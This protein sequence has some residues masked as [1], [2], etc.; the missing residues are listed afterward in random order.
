MT[1]RSVRPVAAGRSRE[2]R[3][4]GVERER[5]EAEEARGLVLQLADAHEV[6]HPVL[7]G[8]DAAVEHRDVRLH[9]VRVA[10]AGD[11]EPAL[12]GDLVAAD[13]VANP[14]FEDLGAAAG[15][16][17]HARRLQVPDDVDDVPLADARDPVELHHRPRLEM[18]ARKARLERAEE[19]E[20]PGVG[21]RRVEAAHDVELRDPVVPARR[22]LRDGFLDRH[23]VAA[24][25]AGLARPGAQR[26]VHPAEVRRIQIAIHVVVAGV[27]VP[28]L[29]HEVRERADAEDVLRPEQGD[30]VVEREPAAFRDLFGDRKE[31]R[32]GETLQE[33]AQSGMSPLAMG[34][35]RAGGFCCSA[36]ALGFSS[37]Y[38]PA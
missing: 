22:G 11:L 5:D 10:E 20:V 8:L 24:V 35:E 34:R 27:T 25:H 18:D 15:A 1:L 9:A 23:R 3:F 32:A 28:F 26:A 14:F 31:R 13:D 19:I 36:T 4:L 17:V 21:E 38:R 33:G 37:S 6:V 29:A 16:R 7:D 2:L 30:A 12:A